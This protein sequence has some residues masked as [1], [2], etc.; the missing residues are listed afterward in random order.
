MLTSSTPE[1][2]GAV[3]PCLGAGLCAPAGYGRATE[4]KRR[5]QH[6]RS[7]PLCPQQL[8]RVMEQIN[9]TQE[10]RRDSPGPPSL[11]SGPNRG[12]LLHVM[13]RSGHGSFT[14]VQR[15]VA[16]LFE[17]SGKPVELTRELLR[18][19]GVSEKFIKQISSRLSYLAS[20]GAI[21]IL[22]RRGRGE[23]SVYV[24]KPG[25]R[26]RRPRTG[27][28][29]QASVAPEAGSAPAGAGRSS[30]SLVLRLTGE[31]GRLVLEELTLSV[32]GAEAPAAGEASV[33]IQDRPQP[34]GQ[35]ASP[36]PGSPELDRLL[37]NLARVQE[38]LA[39]LEAEIHA[40]RPASQKLA[41][42]EERVDELQRSLERAIQLASS[43]AG[44]S[45]VVP[46]PKIFAE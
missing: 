41:A 16:E 25:P 36:A 17:A 9:R 19:A 38:D 3:Q 1:P 4:A 46:I 31:E 20:R 21:E 14:T 11:T 13:A 12:Y 23:H 29:R 45:R 5:A 42:L 32:S 18:N 35:A 6:P 24:V 43:R 7:V 26:A 37:R 39:R 28:V 10:R 8:D 33:R 30:Y 44:S 22:E 27:P 2:S 15:L 40:V 34:A